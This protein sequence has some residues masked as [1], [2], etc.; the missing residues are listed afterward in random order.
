MAKFFLVTGYTDMRK[1]IDGLM[2][3]VRDTYELDPYSNSLF[4]FCGRR[5][6]RIK[7]LH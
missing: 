2:A 4:L 5:C 1:S 3:I 6:D 7:A